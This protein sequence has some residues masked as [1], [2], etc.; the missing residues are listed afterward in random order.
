MTKGEAVDNVARAPD[1]LVAIEAELGWRRMTTDGLI[2]WVKGDGR[3]I[4]AFIRSLRALRD[5]DVAQLSRLLRAINGFFAIVVCGPRFS[6]AAVDRVRSIPF[7]FAHRDG[8]WHVDDRALR[9]RDRLGLGPG[10]I[11]SDAALSVAMSGYSIDNAALYKGLQQL[12]PGEFVI[13][14]DGAAGGRHSYDF[15]RPWRPDKPAY[16]AE[17]AKRSLRDITLAIVDEMM[18]GLSGRELVVPLSAGRNSR[19]IVSAA[20]HLGYRNVR[21]FAYG[22]PGN[23][24]ARAS[25]AIA[26]KLGYPWRFV[27]TDAGYMRRYFD[28]S[29]H[30]RYMAACDTTQSTPF[31]QDLPQIMQLKEEEFV[32]ADAV[33]CNGNSGD[34]IS[35]AHVLPVMQRD[36][37][38]MSLE[39]RMDRITDALME[40]HFALWLALMTS[41]NR[42]RT[43]QVLRSAFER[44]GTALAAPRDD[45]GLYE[46]AEFRDRQCKYVISGQRI[47]EFLGHDWRLPLWD[48]VYLDFWE[49]IPLSGKIGQNLYA[50]MLED[51]N[52]GGVWRGMPVNA[53]T[54]RPHWIRPIRFAA[55]LAHAPLGRDRWHR[56]EKRFFHYWMSGTGS[57]ASVPYRSVAMDRRGARNEVSWL[58]EIYLERHGVRWKDLAA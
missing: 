16:D 46:Y 33:L 38:A 52:W 57:S 32:P 13:F 6:F 44:A 25:W 51:E 24:E 34:F 41:K 20:H 14:G 58:T 23:F 55:K 4:D 18:Q 3:G 50:G 56:F 37:T 30:E 26:E 42:A 36:A 9:L 22:R 11:D 10:D 28:S 19:L 12:G 53:K 40:K 15:Y 31:V 8:R 17:K 29:I 21:C 1:V 35:G 43:A 49:G 2:V 39:A 48:G 7:A 5:P 47:Y 27:P 54:I 45:Y